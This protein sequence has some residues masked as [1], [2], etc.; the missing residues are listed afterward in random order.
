V[1]V[2]DNQD[3]PPKPSSDLIAAL[4]A[5]LDERRLLTTEVFVKG[6]RY[7]EVRVEARVAAN[8]YA[9]FDA[10]SLAVLKALDQELDPR[11][12]KFG[13]DLSPTRLYSSILQVPDVTGVLALNIYVDGRRH[14]GLDPITVA[15]DG[16][17]FGLNHIIT[18]EPA[19]D[20]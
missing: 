1:V 20:R 8:P 11:R 17:L 15:A 4:C 10:V 9:S 16:L 13:E 2:P 5:M 6:P 18:V 19:I 12:G 3:K 7:S 14:I